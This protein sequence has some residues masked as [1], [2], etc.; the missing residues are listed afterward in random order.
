M[1]DDRSLDIAC[2]SYDDLNQEIVV[3]I[4]APGWQCH[5]TFGGRF[6]RKNPFVHP[7]KDRIPSHAG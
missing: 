2:K 6:S 7:K 5:D 4:L 3:T 1:A